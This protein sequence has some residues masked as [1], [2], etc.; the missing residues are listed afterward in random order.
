MIALHKS[1]QKD[2]ARLGIIVGKR[3]AK[4]AVQRNQ[5]RRIIRES[6]RQH[7]E[8]LKGLDI[9]VLLRSECTPLID[10]KAWRANIDHLWQL[11]DSYKAD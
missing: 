7:K 8:S 5:L 4:K 3:Y 2:H 9:I 11:I 10:K 6:F 1:N